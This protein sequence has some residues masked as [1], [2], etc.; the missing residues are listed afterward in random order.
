MVKISSAGTTAIPVVLLMR[1]LGIDNDQEIFQ[2][3]AGPTETFKFIVANLNEVKDNEE[4][5]VENQEEA[6]QWLEKKFAAGQQKEYREQRIQ[7]LLDKELL[8][9]LGNTEDNRKKKAI[10]LGRIVRQVLEMAINNKG[11]Q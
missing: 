7:N 8:P 4:Y 5:N 10:F 9:H 3:I 6:M 1:S 11:A 2:A